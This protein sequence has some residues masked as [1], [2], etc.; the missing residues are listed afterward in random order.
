MVFML[1]VTTSWPGIGWDGG[2]Y[3]QIRDAF[4]RHRL[5]NAIMGACL[6]VNHTVRDLHDSGDSI[7][8]IS[9]IFSGTL[10]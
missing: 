9:G 10:S 6:P 3:R 4:G 7:L 1:L 8:T 5:Y 2:T